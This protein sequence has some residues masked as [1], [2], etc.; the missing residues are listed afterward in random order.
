MK[1]KK[2]FPNLH[3]AFS[4]GDFVVHHT[5]RK[6]SGLPMDQALEKVQQ[7]SQRSRRSDRNHK[8]ERKQCKMDSF[9]AREE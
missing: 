5:E 4:R 3:E 6:G 1:L 2:N 8:K 7:A 9:E